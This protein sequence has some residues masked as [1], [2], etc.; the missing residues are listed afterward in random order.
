MIRVGRKKDRTDRLA[1][2]EKKRQTCRVERQR[3]RHSYGQGRQTE[4]DRKG[5]QTDR[6]VG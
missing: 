3:D 4:T 6:L 2:K 1:G 5:R